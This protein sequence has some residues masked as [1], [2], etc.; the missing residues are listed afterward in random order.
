MLWGRLVILPEWGSGDPG[1]NPGSVMFP[2]EQSE[3]GR[4]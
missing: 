4:H 1:A 2:S 3:L